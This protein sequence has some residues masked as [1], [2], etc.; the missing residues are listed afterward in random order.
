MRLVR[1]LALACALLAPL[2]VLAQSVVPAYRSAAPITPGTPVSSGDGVALAC[3]VGGTL[4]LVM[5]D[6]SL[7]DFYAQQGTA[8]VDNL[9]VKDVSAAGT[10][11]TCSVTVLRRG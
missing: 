8:I 5:H 3:S 9:A 4:R 7:L 10:S 6:G 11:A 1:T 2:P